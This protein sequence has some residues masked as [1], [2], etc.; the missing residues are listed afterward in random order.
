M[1][2]DV[3]SK[4]FDPTTLKV[5]T[6]AR[7]LVLQDYHEKRAW[8]HDR[9]L[10]DSEKIWAAHKILLSYPEFPAYPTEQEIM[11]TARE[12]LDHLRNPISDA[13]LSK[14]SMILERDPTPVFPMEPVQPPTPEPEIPV[15]P[16]AE[17]A[18]PDDMEV[19]VVT[20]VE[21]KEEYEPAPEVKEP[22]TKSLYD[23]I[24]WVIGKV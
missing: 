16:P 18:P 22:A 24:S 2:T 14:V 21:Q 11:A 15:E 8:L 4:S 19:E 9:W 5:I 17:T 6:I 3:F 13:D 7:E 20:V 12:I 23:K 1:I 10:N